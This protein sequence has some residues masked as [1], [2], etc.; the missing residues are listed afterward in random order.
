MVS[1]QDCGTVKIIPPE[2]T[3]IKNPFSKIFT[4]ETFVVKSA[5]VMSHPTTP[6]KFPF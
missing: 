6:K 1:F 2:L 3:I 5:K 4:F